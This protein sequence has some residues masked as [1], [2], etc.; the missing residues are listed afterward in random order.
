VT[1][2]LGLY[3]AWLGAAGVL[4]AVG[5]GGGAQPANAA[6]ARSL[7][8]APVLAPEQ[9]PSPAG[10]TDR[11]P[12]PAASVGRDLAGSVVF[13]P[14]TVVLPDGTSAPVVPVGLHPDGALVVP[15]DVDT[16][17]WWTGGSRAGEPFGSVVVAG[18]VDSAAR[19]IGV[20][21]QLKGLVPGQVVELAD[22]SHH[23]R[24]RIAS[25]TLVPQARL[26]EDAGI[27]RV[28]GEPQLVLVTC[29]GAFDPARHRYQDNLVVIAT[30]L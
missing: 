2:A 3:G 14:T 13:V 7:T 10:G 26:A 6:P 17:G 29:G 12:A 16:V 23:A 15:D 22:G 5:F 1:T 27:F 21:A 25:A 20:F 24:Y 18:H 30:P 4:V 11:A 9:P 8:P 19:G 28:D